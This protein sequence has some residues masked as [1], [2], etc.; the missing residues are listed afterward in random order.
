MFVGFGASLRSDTPAP[1]M[2]EGDIGPRQATQTGR[3]TGLKR[4]HRFLSAPEPT[5]RDGLG[6][7]LVNALACTMKATLTK[8]TQ[9]DSV[10]D[11]WYKTLNF[12][13]APRVSRKT[14]AYVP[15]VR[16]FG[17][18]QK[19]FVCPHMPVRTFAGRNRACRQILST[20]SRLFCSPERT[21]SVPQTQIDQRIRKASLTKN[22]VNYVLLFI[23]GGRVP[24]SVH[25]EFVGTMS[26]CGIASDGRFC[27]NSSGVR[28]CNPR[29]ADSRTARDNEVCLKP[30]W[31]DCGSIR[32]SRLSYHSYNARSHSHFHAAGKTSASVQKPHFPEL[33]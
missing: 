33:L 14:R 6:G 27:T 31:H 18:F 7:S 9:T 29:P 22:V 12:N 30:F 8:T 4:T 2:V 19:V 24:P 3:N 17:R 5:R 32:G 10:S 21:L 16:L 23:T 25:L 13:S 11:S 26:R 1:T 15:C 28:M 20:K